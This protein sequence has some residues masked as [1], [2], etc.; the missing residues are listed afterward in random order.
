MCTLTGKTVFAG[1]VALLAGDFNPSCFY[2][3]LSAHM[4][5]DPSQMGQSSLL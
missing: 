4:V 3:G 1:H 5:L 2:K